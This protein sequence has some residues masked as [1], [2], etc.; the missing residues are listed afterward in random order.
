[1]ASIMK[2][3]LW[4]GKF[5]ARTVLRSRASCLDTIQKNLKHVLVQKM[6]K[7]WIL[8]VATIASMPLCGCA[9]KEPVK[10]Y[11]ITQGSHLAVRP[12]PRDFEP[13]WMQ[14]HQAVLDRIHQ[15][16]VAIIMIGDSITQGWEFAGQNVWNKYYQSRNAVN[17]GFN[18]D[19]THHVLWRLQNGEIESLSPCLAVVMIGTNNSG[20]SS[21][22]EIADGIILIC[23]ELRKKLPATKILLLS[24]FPRDTAD[25]N[26]RRTNTQA[27]EIASK[28]AD[29]R[30]IY[31][32]D[33]NS[34]FLDTNTELSKEIMPDKLHPNENGYQIWAQSMEP[35]IAKLMKSCKH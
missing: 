34:Y 17:L 10:Q 20:S 29:N 22:R 13:W 32:L 33:I 26:S 3:I 7:V 27:S 18:G 16:N 35:M 5:D 14:R 28:I 25:S 23:Q 31:Y 24:I 1:M 4:S 6:K 15:G 30:W 9:V 19:G 21:G 11:R 12:F 2:Q 8:I